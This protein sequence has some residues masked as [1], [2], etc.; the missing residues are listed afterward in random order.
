MRREAPVTLV[1]DEYPI[2]Q[3]LNVVIVLAQ[4]AAFAG[5]VWAA[6]E[7]ETWLGL[8][9]LAA[10]FGILMNSVYSVIH[11]SEH[12]SLLR[13]RRANDGVG[14]LMALLFPAPFH[15]IRQGHLGHHVRNRSDDEAFD[16]IFPGE[17]PVW[18]GLQFYGILTGL[19][20]VMVALS[21]LVVLLLPSVL[22]RRNFEFDRPTAALVDS[23]EPTRW[24]VIRAEAAA[25]IALHVG[26]VVGAQVPW[27]NYC[28][29]YLGFGF[30]W[31]A[32]QYV[33]HYGTERHVL[34]GAR[35]LWLWAPID[36]V[37]LHHNWHRTH[38]LQPSVPWIHLPTLS[39]QGPVERGFLPW[40][41]L[42]MWRG[43]RTAKAGEAVSQESPGAS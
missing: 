17:S 28:V 7:V 33:H 21:N 15:L 2:P 27:L 8:L 30:S 24:G 26:L 25:A 41:Y 40:A 23:L 6:R 13:S 12:R 9:G 20:W 1:R 37:W 10:V 34:R 19:Y 4:L 43:P 38:H 18:K 22:V 42:R 36:W 14:I 32:M 35:N 39:R 29:M 11:E 31:S 16:Y 3:G 5:C